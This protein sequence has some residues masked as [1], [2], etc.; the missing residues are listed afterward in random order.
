M[1]ICTSQQYEPIAEQR[2]IDMK[3]DDCKTLIDLQYVNTTDENKFNETI[4]RIYM[5][6]NKICRG[7]TK[8][9]IRCSKRLSVI[10]NLLSKYGNKYLRFTSIHTIF[11]SWKQNTIIINDNNLDIINRL[12]SNC[13]RTENDKNEYK[14]INKHIVNIFTLAVDYNIP[15]VSNDIKKMIISYERVYKQKINELYVANIFVDMYNDKLK[16][17]INTIDFDDEKNLN[18]GI[19]VFDFIKHMINSFSPDEMLKYKKFLTRAV[20][21]YG[22]ILLLPHNYI[23]YD[24]KDLVEL[25]KIGI[26][27]IQPFL[28]NL[29]NRVS[30]LKN[31]ELKVDSKR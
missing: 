18:H 9:Y 21:L 28:R 12:I 6:N 15:I 5:E 27:F 10:D 16:Y 24:L 17:L 20:N 23:K 30:L 3:L 22:L 7:I 19:Y 29:I 26:L 4:N 8:L 2:L 11:N 25:S 31:D 14:C 13:I 1:G